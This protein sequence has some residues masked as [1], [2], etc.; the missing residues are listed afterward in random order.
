MLKPESRVRI[1]YKQQDLTDYT[2]RAC[3]VIE[4]ILDRNLRKDPCLA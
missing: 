4:E 2:L 1:T 3:Q